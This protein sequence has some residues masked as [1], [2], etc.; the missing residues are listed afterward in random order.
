MQIFYIAF[1][2]SSCLHRLV[3]MTSHS[4]RFSLN[5]IL[6]QR[7][8]CTL[9]H[10]YF[11]SVAVA[12]VDDDVIATADPSDVAVVVI[13]I[14]LHVYRYVCKSIH[15]LVNVNNVQYVII[16]INTCVTVVVS[17]TYSLTHSLVH[18]L[19]IMRPLNTHKHVHNQTHV[20]MC[21]SVFVCASVAATHSKHFL[22]TT[23]ACDFIILSRFLPT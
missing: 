10:F 23:L 20:N 14:H 9:R 1:Y 5:N 17:L 4:A 16:T 8:I 15:M 13:Y 12:V 6:M 11:G 21:V 22:I 3:A 19:S 18:S 2:A 7:C